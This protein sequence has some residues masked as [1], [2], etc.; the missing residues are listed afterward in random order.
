MLANRFVSSKNEGGYSVLLR[1]WKE[2]TLEGNDF[3]RKR[4]WKETTLEGNDFFEKRRLK[5]KLLPNEFYKC[6]FSIFP[7][8]YYFTLFY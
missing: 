3:G 6:Y 5:T 8:T 4:L 7:K 1:L 2:T